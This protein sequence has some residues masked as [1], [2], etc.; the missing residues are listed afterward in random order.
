MGIGFGQ[1]GDGSG[2]LSYPIKGC[3]KS[4]GTSER[5]RFELSKVEIILISFHK[6]L[7]EVALTMSRA[8]TDRFHRSL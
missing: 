8:E 7:G 5:N 6:F 1:S 2:G 4:H 3:E